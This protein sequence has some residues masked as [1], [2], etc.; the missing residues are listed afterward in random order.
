MVYFDLKAIEAKLDRAFKTG[1]SIDCI[2]IFNGIPARTLGKAA[3]LFNSKNSKLKAIVIPEPPPEM[4]DAIGV[5]VF[6]IGS[7]LHRDW[8]NRSIGIGV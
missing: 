5:A 6:V 2:V 3:H 4:P 7:K 1:G 8:L